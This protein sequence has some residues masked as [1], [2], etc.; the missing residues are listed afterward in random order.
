MK[1]VGSLLSLSSPAD[2]WTFNPPEGTNFPL[3]SRLGSSFQQ[4]DLNEVP[5]VP[6]DLKDR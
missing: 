3:K 4:S 2:S 5:L 6:I 1:S